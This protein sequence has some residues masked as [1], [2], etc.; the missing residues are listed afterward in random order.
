MSSTYLFQYIRNCYD[1]LPAEDRSRYGELWKAYEQI[2]GDLYTKT[3]EV[4]YNTTVTNLLTYNTERWNSFPFD[5][6]T[7]I[8][9]AASL[10]GLLNLTG[11]VDLTNNYLLNITFTVTNPAPPP[12]YIPATFQIDVRG[13]NPAKTLPTE[14]VA[15]INAAVGFSFAS[16]NKLNQV[17]LTTQTTGPQAYITLSPASIPANDAMLFIFGYAPATLPQTFP[18]F[19]FV[20]TLNE[21]TV[22]RI[23]ILQDFIRD[24]NVTIMLSDTN[25]DYAVEH[26]TGIIT[27]AKQPI[28]LLWARNTLLNLETPYKNFGYLLDFYDQNSDHYVQS[29]KGLWYAFWV[30]PKPNNILRALYLLFDLPVA[31]NSGVVRSVTPTTITFQE[32][33]PLGPDGAGILDTITVPLGLTPAVTV[34]ER[35]VQFDPFTNGISI[36]DHSNDPG[37]LTTEVG[38]IGIGNYLTQYASLGS[39]PNSDETK[40]LTTCEINTFLVQVS[41]NAFVINPLNIGNIQTFLKKIRPEAKTFLFQILVVAEDTITTL[42]SY[43]ELDIN[44]DVTPNVDYNPWLEAD[45]TVLDAAENGTFTTGTGLDSEVFGELETTEIDVYW[46]ASLVDSFT[47]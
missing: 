20:Y 13:V 39:S 34:G 43:L 10:T 27:F 11:G 8:T 4:D 22:Y 5:S 36:L 41:S 38:T 23:P 1:L 24:E 33:S 18:Q 6:T 32:D 47:F 46:H 15:K 30:G 42:D 7:Q 31:A 12:A 16:L 9:R 17:I 40:A 28:A 35:L 19:P 25:N 37:F 2:V 29:I 14:I 45:P 26:G 21:P 44:F 3:V